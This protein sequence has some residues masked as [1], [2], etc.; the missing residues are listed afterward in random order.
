M[1][2]TEP[3]DSG[4]E[5]KNGHYSLESSAST[6]LRKDRT[7]PSHLVGHHCVQGE[8][9]KV[10]RCLIPGLLMRFEKLSSEPRNRMGNRVT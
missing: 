10:T 5:R 9:P 3:M 6:G 7:R 2:L 4:V 8:V 1:D